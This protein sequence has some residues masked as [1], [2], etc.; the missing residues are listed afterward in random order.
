MAGGYQ[1]IFLGAPGSGKGTQAARAVKEWGLKHISTGDLLRR[2]I[3][4]GSALGPRIKATLDS[5]ALVDDETVLEL[6]VANCDPSRHFYI[7]DGLP[8]N[9]AQ[10]QALDEHILRGAPSRAFHF[11]IAPHKLLERLVNRRSCGQCGAIFNLES[12]PPREE[13]VCDDCG[14]R[15]LVHRED[16]REEVVNKRMATFQEE[17][18]PILEHYES[19]K[20]LTEVDASLESEVIF[21]RIRSSLS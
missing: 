14:H 7:F 18:D 15:G 13:D 4:S 11:R 19:G 21:G 8:R 17:I 1:L 2:E 5:G 16:D 20:R 12:R 6:L 10:A 9:R 3:D